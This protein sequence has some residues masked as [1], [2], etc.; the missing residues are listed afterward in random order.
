M[1]LYNLTELLT[2]ICPECGSPVIY[3]PNPCYMAICQKCSFNF[4][5]L[6][7][8]NGIFVEKALKAIEER[9]KEIKLIKKYLV[10]KINICEEDEKNDGGKKYNR[11]DI[12]DI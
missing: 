9:E 7:L 6:R 4:F 2:D 12:M 1:I 11:F 3:H 10:E 5:T 8:K